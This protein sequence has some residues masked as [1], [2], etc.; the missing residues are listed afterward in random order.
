VTRSQISSRLAGS[1]RTSSMGFA[2][3]DKLS[4]SF[5]VLLPMEG[6]SN[7]LSCGFHA[8]ADIVVAAGA[9]LIAIF[10]CYPMYI[11]AVVIKAA[12]RNS[13]KDARQKRCA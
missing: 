6:R 4:N 8:I 11:A 13:S 9:A 10:V 3:L 1:F 2:Q 7:L 12:W 5:R